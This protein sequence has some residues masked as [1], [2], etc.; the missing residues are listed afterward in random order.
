MRRRADDRG[1]AMV[2]VLV[3]AAVISILAATL[4]QSVFRQVRPSDRTERSY[5]A[6]A[7]AEAGVEDMR[8]RLATD[9]EYWRKVRDFYAGKAGSAAIGTAN[10]ALTTWVDVPGGTSKAQFSYW[11]DTSTAARNGRLIISAT[12]RA[13]ESG[14]QSMRTIEAVL[15][16]RTTADYAYMSNSEAYA[17]DTPGMYQPDG[18]T[19]QGY[20]TKE[21]AKAVCGDGSRLWYEW[22]NWRYADGSVKNG[23]AGTVSFNN[24]TI[25]GTGPHRNSRACFFGTLGTNT[26]WAGPMHT[27][28]VW[29]IADPGPGVALA[30]VTGPLSSSCPGVSAGSA[31]NATCITEHRWINAGQFGSAEGLG[32]DSSY[33][34]YVPAEIP[35]TS[36]DPSMNRTWN[37]TYEGKLELPEGVAAMRRAALEDGGC[38]YYGPTRFRFGTD[39]VGGVSR[40]WVQITS[41]DTKTVNHDYCKG[42]AALAATNVN[43]HPTSP[44]LYYDDMQRA[45][46][47]GVLYVEQARTA[48]WSPS[49]P[50]SCATKANGSPFPFIIPDPAS[51]PMAVV[52]GTP[53][54]FPASVTTWTGTTLSGS[55]EIDEWTDPAMTRCARADVYVEAAKGGTSSGTSSYGDPSNSGGYT[56]QFAVVAG[57]D[58]AVPGDPALTGGDIVITNDIVDSS[59]TNFVPSA[60]VTNWGVPDPGSTSLMGLVPSRYVYI[61][62]VAGKSV[63]NSA[64]LSNGLTGALKDAVLDVEILAPKGCLALQDFDAN[65]AMGYLKVVGS[66]GQD[67]RCRIVPG[68]GPGYA[69]WTVQYDERLRSLG[70][71]PFMA[72][73]SAEP[74]RIEGW[75]ETEVRRDQVAK[76]EVAPIATIGKAGVSARHDVISPAQEAAGMKLVFARITSGSGTLTADTTTGEVVFT[77]PAGVTSTTIEFVLRKSDGSLVGQQLVVASS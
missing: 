15:V 13:G 1:A 26:S 2:I 67:N 30:N 28:D 6:W 55:L 3:W 58:P 49:L 59:V 62:H 77:P 69:N 72:E 10:P 33:A 41:P 57:S 20:L 54:G 7:A 60:S 34:S 12:G 35:T 36:T 4:M 74:W 52:P 50:P 27:N 14:D 53:K 21:V 76:S 68:N 44:K 45:G 65:P 39:V 11:I 75:S 40:G 73:L 29:Y 47:N 51:E 46:F 8:V 17:W 19:S 22:T 16:K 63:T 31:L 38:V 18:S 37:P 23:P 43:Q 70:S 64:G 5:D 48:D 61:Y 71:P 24:P 42:A 9:G 25:T 66:L 32:K 56:G